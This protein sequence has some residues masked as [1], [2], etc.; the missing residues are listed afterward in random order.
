MNPELDAYL[1]RDLYPRVWRRHDRRCFD[2]STAD[3]LTQETYLV[4]FGPAYQRIVGF[5]PDRRRV[6]GFVFTIA[7]NVWL[8]HL[9]RQRH[10]PHPLPGGEEEAVLGGDHTAGVELDEY[11]A[12]EARCVRTLTP[13]R[14]CAYLLRRIEA[15]ETGRYDW[16]ALWKVDEASYN[17]YVRE[18]EPRNVAQHYHHAKRTV[19]EC[20]ARSGVNPFL[21]NL[22]PMDEPS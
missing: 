19:L 7:R 13:N 15:D 22:T 1:L 18:T 6:D 2:A 11:V 12:A 21:Q 5:W 17:L 20:L 10:R 14:R 9:R 3:E 4:V 16:F 8:D